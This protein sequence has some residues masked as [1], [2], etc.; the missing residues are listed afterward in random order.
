MVTWDEVSV[1]LEVIL[2]LLFKFRGFQAG[3]V[4][5]QLCH[6]CSQLSN[7]N[8]AVALRR[9]LGKEDSRA[10]TDDLLEISGQFGAGNFGECQLVFDKVFRS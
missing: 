8:I 6:V 4:A 1:L 5:K 9:G 7:G 3:L 10:L 2:R